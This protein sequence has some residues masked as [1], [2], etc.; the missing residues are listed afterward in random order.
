MVLIDQALRPKRGKYTT[1][2]QTVNQS[3]KQLP[4]NE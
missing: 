3:T 2:Y 1:I 4:D